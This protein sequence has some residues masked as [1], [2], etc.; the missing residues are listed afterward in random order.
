MRLLSRH[1]E[2]VIR[3]QE[4]THRSSL[5]S[6]PH[7]SIGHTEPQDEKLLDEVVATLQG[8]GYKV[9]LRTFDSTDDSDWGDTRRRMLRTSLSIMKRDP[10]FSGFVFIGHGEDPKGW[11]SISSKRSISPGEF[12]DGMKHSLDFMWLYSCYGLRSSFE[13]SVSTEGTLR[14]SEGSTN[15][16]KDRQDLKSAVHDLSKRKVDPKK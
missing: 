5:H 9:R 1:A 6:V 16:I 4:R 14:G 15:A 10:C 11:L 13:R 2:P 3:S 12:D 7:S 8:E